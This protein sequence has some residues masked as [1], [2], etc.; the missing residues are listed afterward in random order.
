[1][2][3]KAAVCEN[4]GGNLSVDDARE[5]G[6][7]PYCGTKYYTEKIVNNN[8]VTNN[9]N[10]EQPETQGSSPPDL[11]EEPGGLWYTFGR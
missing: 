1:M 2:A 5:V 7:C 11:L 6:Y 8:Y 10:G 3:L 9:Y 4:C